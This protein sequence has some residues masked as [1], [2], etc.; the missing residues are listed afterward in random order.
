[1][2]DIGIELNELESRVAVLEQTLANTVS[3]LADSYTD[4][5][6]NVTVTNDPLDWTVAANGW[7]SYSLIGPPIEDP[8]DPYYPGGVVS[9]PYA[10]PA[11]Y[12]LGSMCVLTGMVRRKAGATSLVAGVRHNSPMFALP[13][14]WQPTA[15]FILPCLVGSSD[16]TGYGLIGTGW[17]EIRE[18]DDLDTGVVSFVA[19][20]L[21][22]TSDT[23][24]ISL[25]GLFP[26]RV[27]DSPALVEDSWDDASQ[28]TTWDMVD[29]TITWNSY[30]NPTS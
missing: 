17:V 1:M 18:N 27:A 3:G 24:W 5:E 15:D 19:S 4:T 9:T 21:A 8:E 23:G 2:A 10:M 30:P 28:T 25:Q 13:Q 7:E 6:N 26:I 12:R 11:A 14:F 16:P 20:T 29:S 22:L